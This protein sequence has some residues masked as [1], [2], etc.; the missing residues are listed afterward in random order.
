MNKPKKW[1]KAAQFCAA[2]LVY[3]AFIT[4]VI[5]LVS[6]NNF[7]LSRIFAYSDLLLEG[8]KNVLIIS[9]L[10]LFFGMILGFVLYVMQKSSVY[11]IKSLANIFIEVI[12]G[13]PLLVLVFM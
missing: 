13:T 2:L 9:G 3:A 6:P 11:F 7:D 4:L 10:S 1:L 8:M 5:V 12:M